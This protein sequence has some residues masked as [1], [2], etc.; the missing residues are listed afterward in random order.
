MRFI[1]AIA[2]SLAAGLSYASPIEKR[3]ST[4]MVNDG[5]ILNY[6]L[7]LEYLERK[8]YQEGLAN[9]TQA[10]FVA[11]G[12]ADPFYKNLKQI[13]FDEQT[14]VSFLSDALTA[15]HITPTVE[16]QYSFGVTDVKS[17]LTLSSVLEGVDVSA[18][19]GAAA[20]IMNKDYLTAAGTILTV[21]ARHTSYI[22]AE[23]GESPFPTPF[24]TPLDFNQ[25][26]SI[27][28]SRTD[29]ANKSSVTFTNGF[30]NACAFDN[31]IRADTPIYAV[32]FSGLMKLPVQVRITRGNQDYKIDT[33]PGGVM[34]QVYVVLS[35]S[36]TDFSDEN[37]IAGP[38][39]IEVYPMGQTPSMPHPKCM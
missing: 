17:F 33:I 15:A 38:S 10:Q 23:I 35:K 37:I 13:Y 36:R 39:I 3:V 27:A 11:A 29:G 9:Y 12:F 20:S 1:N 4:P 24:D 26:K 19:L 18:Y 7:T 32:F 34:G 2:V 22:R 31:S 14:H 16:L 30:T 8:F 28:A 25:G 21:E 5:I 6:A